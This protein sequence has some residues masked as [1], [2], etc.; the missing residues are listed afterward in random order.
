MRRREG[1]LQS[2]A[3]IDYDF[4]EEEVAGDDSR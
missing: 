2:G 1:S 3:I 4:K